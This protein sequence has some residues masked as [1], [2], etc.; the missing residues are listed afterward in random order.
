MKYVLIASAIVLLSALP[1]VTEAAGPRSGYQ[2]VNN[3]YNYN[4]NVN[5]AGPG[6][7]TAPY[8]YGYGYGNRYRSRGLETHDA[9]VSRIKATHSRFRYNT[10]PRS[11]YNSPPHYYDWR[12]W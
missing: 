9:A 6:R 12:G 5:Q 7:Y 8:G 1:E 3:N 11:H 4:Y 2:I 10:H